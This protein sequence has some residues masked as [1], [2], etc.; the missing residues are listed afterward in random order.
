MTLTVTQP[1]D[2]L[3]SINPSSIVAGSPDTTIT[4]TGTNFLPS[5]VAQDNGAPLATT[6]VNATTLTAVVPTADLTTPG[7]EAITVATPNEPLTGRRDADGDGRRGAVADQHRPG[8]HGG[9]Q[10]GHDHHV[11]RHQLHAPVGGPGQRHADRD[12][13]RQPDAGRRP[14]S[15]PPT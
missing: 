5:S 13:V 8:H 9:R 7:T 2:T 15:P 10:P 4:L 6:F 14:S 12:H 3:T 1:N 11:D